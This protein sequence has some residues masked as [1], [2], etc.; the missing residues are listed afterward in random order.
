MFRQEL[1]GME[2][3][4]LLE[5]MCLTELGKSDIKAIGKARGFSPE[6]TAP[7]ERLRQALLSSTGVE[8]VLASLTEKERLALH[9]L[10][11]LGSDVDLRFFERIYPSRTQAYSFQERFKGVFQQ[12]RSRLVL[13]GILLCAVPPAGWLSSKATVLERRRFLFP[14][15]LADFLPPLVRPVRFEPPIG[16]ASR[17]DVARRKLAE[18]VE[19]QSAGSSAPAVPGD[20]FILEDGRLHLGKVRFSLA[21]L[22]EWQL[23]GAEKAARFSVKCSECPL[24]P[25]RLAMYALARLGTQEWAAVEELTPLWKLANFR[26]QDQPAPQ[27]VCQ[28]GWEWGCLERV[29]RDGITWYRLSQPDG[30][31]AQS[32]PDDYLNAQHR[33]A[34]EIN[35]QRIPLQVLERLSRMCTMKVE[36]RRLFAYPDLIDISHLPQSQAQDPILLWLREH[37]PA[38][39]SVAQDID[40]RRGKTVVHSNL[41]MARVTDLSLKVSLEKELSGAGRLIS[42]SD[43]FIAFPCQLLSDVQRRVKKTGHVVKI[44]NADE[45]D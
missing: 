8:R 1:A 38:F 6:E 2:K 37:H 43:E 11:A 3:D 18:I 22:R 13:Q 25:L 17:N 10:S 7:P 15:E 30:Q 23:K 34:V 36:N 19:G 5:K 42:L 32:Q 31:P 12:V 16:R 35:V 4:E 44:V 45:R 33:Q 21:A 41:L 26:E 9:L 24:S 27:A 39:R 40:L 28:G 20:P 29:E 14:P